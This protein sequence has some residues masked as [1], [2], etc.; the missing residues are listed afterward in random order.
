M[1]SALAKKIIILIL[2]FF[3]LASNIYALPYPIPLNGKISLNLII[4]DAN[5]QLDTNKGSLVTYL[6]RDV[7]PLGNGVLGI[8]NLDQD[9]DGDVDILSKDGETV[10]TAHI[11]NSNSI[12]IVKNLVFDASSDASLC[13][14]NNQN[15]MLCTFSLSMQQG[16]KYVGAIYFSV[17]LNDFDSDLVNF[18]I[19][20]QNA[21]IGSGTMNSAELSVDYPNLDKITEYF[22]G[23]VNY[24]NKKIVSS[25]Q[26]ELIYL[27]ESSFYEVKDGKYGEPEPV[28]V[29]A[30]TDT[31]VD[32]IVNKK[33]IGQRAIDQDGKIIK[34]D[35]IVPLDDD[36]GGFPDSDRDGIPDE[37]DKCPDSKSLPVDKVGCDCEQKCGVSANCVVE[38]SELLC[39]Q[40]CPENAEIPEVEESSCND[41]NVC[42]C[43]N[44]FTC[45][46][47][48]SCQISVQLEGKKCKTNDF[49]YELEDINC[50]EEGEDW[51]KEKLGN[52]VKL[53]VGGFPIISW[54]V[55]KKALDK[56][57]KAT[58]C[59]KTE[60]FG[61]SLPTTKCFG[62]N[63]MTDDNKGKAAEILK[64]E[65]ETQ[66]DLPAI[67][68]FFVGI[69]VEVDLSNFRLDIPYSCD[70]ITINSKNSC[71]S[72]I[73]NGD[74]STKADILFIG[75]GFCNEQQLKETVI[76]VVDYDGNNAN[77]Q[78]SGFFSEEAYKSNKN[79]FN[80]WYMDSQNNINYDED[81]YF[82]A[83]GKLPVYKNIFSLS[84]NCPWYDYIVLLSKNNDYR[85]NCM[86]GKP[87]PCRISIMQEEYPGRLLTHELGHG[88]ASLA[89]E[90]YNIVERKDNQNS[91]ESFYSQ[92]LIGPNC[93]Q[94]KNEAESAWGSLVGDNI[95]FFD[96]CGGDCDS[97]C[98]LY[99]KP[100]YNSIMNSQDEFCDPAS[101]VYQCKK[102]PP[103]DEFYAV[104]ELE[105]INELNKYS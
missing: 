75:D 49:F 87:G 22:Y 2:A 94:N 7:Q 95:G 79:K 19:N 35:L 102:G 39:E 5:I 101:G 15:Q 33:Y 82:P 65:I 81:N 78:K 64:R 60:D 26:L 12:A 45:Q 34:L 83:M 61:C 40:K 74:T 58:L 80:I 84:N 70:S 41:C 53:D 44:R 6:F 8:E 27:G 54:I 48:G 98:S 66:I 28:R 89:D 92:F 30:P 29:Y 32:F 103:F 62:E 13:M 86:L 72:L 25:G 9:F 38:D 76:E 3:M 104:N 37:K 36:G 73:K 46:S 4:Y 96:G 31:L 99:I 24:S 42:G 55:K 18:L 68:D 97:E 56:L 21:N 63:Q 17:N 51:T 77:T 67:V 1:V 93:R 23:D 105:I 11:T 52:Y 91:L 47:D 50:Q 20:T 59:I 85:S 69:D 90:Y 14:P 88:F 100:T 43:Q 10:G 71:K 57:K 16:S